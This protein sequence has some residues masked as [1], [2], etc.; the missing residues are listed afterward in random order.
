MPWLKKSSRPTKNMSNGENDLTLICEGVDV[1]WAGA[2]EAWLIRL[3]EA[4]GFV[5]W[6]V[7]VTLC[8]DAAIQKLNREYRGK[9][10]P[11]DVL[12]FEAD[13][14]PGS[15]GELPAGVLCGDLVISLPMVKTNSEYFQVDEEEELRRLSVHG[16]LHL[17]G[18]DH[19]T[20][21][22]QEP[23]LI[24]QEEIL[25]ALGKEKVF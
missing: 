3:L 18:W 19:S 15:D 2:Y 12:S 20:N 14:E 24:R 23:M 22:P 11:T 21:D 9:D 1:P 8:D 6:E 10:E 16:F 5:R 13:P 25:G 4:L 7:S 17:A